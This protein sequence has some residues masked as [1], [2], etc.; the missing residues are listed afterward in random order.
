LQHPLVV[1]VIVVIVVVEVEV[2]VVDVVIVAVVVVVVVA[3]LTMVS[4]QELE[5]SLYPYTCWK[6]IGEQRGLT[7]ITAA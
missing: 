5:H 7:A 6:V 1:V 3:G 4:P 2:V